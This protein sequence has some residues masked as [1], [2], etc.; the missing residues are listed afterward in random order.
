[1]IILYIY[2]EDSISVI[3]YSIQC[4]NNDNNNNNNKKNNYNNSFAFCF[5]Y[6]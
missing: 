2:S 1:M 6:I 4:N 3:L 5:L